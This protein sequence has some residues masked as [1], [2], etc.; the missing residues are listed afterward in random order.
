[1]KGNRRESTGVRFSHV[2]SQAWFNPWYHIWFPKHGQ[3]WSKTERSGEGKEE[4]KRGGEG[5][6]GKAKGVKGRRGEEVRRRGEGGRKAVRQEGEEGREGGREP[7]A[8]RLR[9]ASLGSLGSR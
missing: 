9:P 6:G 1:M 2:A 4:E 7:V 3:E 5:K 8:S